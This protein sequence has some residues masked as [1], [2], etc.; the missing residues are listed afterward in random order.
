[1]LQIVVLLLGY[2][3]SSELCSRERQYSSIIYSVDMF[4]ADLL[5]GNSLSSVTGCLF[6]YSNTYSIRPPSHPTSGRPTP[7]VQSMR[8]W[9]ENDLGCCPD[10]YSKTVAEANAKQPPQ[11][12]WSLTGVTR[13]VLAPIYWRQP[14]NTLKVRVFT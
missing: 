6:A 1:M 12:P 8:F 13:F 10:Q 3:P 5:K 11:S 14:L 2:L 9:E 4:F 7:E